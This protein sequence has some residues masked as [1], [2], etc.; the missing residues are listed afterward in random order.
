MFQ[1]ALLTLDRSEFGD[2][3]IPAAAALNVADVVVME[4]EESVASILAHDVPAFDV[5][6][7]V[8]AGIETAE[9]EA[10][11]HHLEEAA[12]QLRSLG[13]PHV[14]TLTCE[15]K[16]GPQIVQVASA[17]GC[18]V[19]VMSTH[20]RSGLSRMLLGSV[21]GY[22]VNHIDAGTSVLLVRPR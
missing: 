18:D 17:Q 10:V 22:V 1:R 4:V 15:G 9:R 11:H 12:E 3:A 2:A 5:P 16:P 13:V 6:A 21:A 14:S 7:D 20:G 8:A 19:I